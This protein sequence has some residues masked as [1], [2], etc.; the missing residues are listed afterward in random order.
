MDVLIAAT[1]YAHGVR[2]YT[3]NSE[4]LLRGLKTP[5]DIASV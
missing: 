2:L 4:D 1:A 3:A 5:V